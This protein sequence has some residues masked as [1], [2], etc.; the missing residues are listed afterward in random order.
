MVPFTFF[1]FSFLSIIIQK[2]FKRTIFII[3]ILILSND[4]YYVFYAD[5]ATEMEIKD[6]LEE[7]TLMK[8]IGFHKNIINLIGCS[9]MLKPF[10]LVLD[11]MPH[12]DLLYYLRRKRKNVGNHVIIITNFV[13][14]LNCCISKVIHMK[15]CYFVM[16][17]TESMFNFCYK[18]YYDGFYL[19]NKCLRQGFL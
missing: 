3:L 15:L 18:L 11:Y 6:F 19:T 12:G 9:T 4:Y 7:I 17:V 5:M 14:E 16:V 13:V 8:S 10:F 1:K 2:D